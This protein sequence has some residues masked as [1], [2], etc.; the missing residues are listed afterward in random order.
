PPA[1][2]PPMQEREL[3]RRSDPAPEASAP[4]VAVKLDPF[5]AGMVEELE[6]T[7][8]RPLPGAPERVS[9]A[10]PATKPPVIDAPRPFT[11]EAAAPVIPV[12]E[13]L[14]PES[15]GA[16]QTSP[17]EAPPEV[18]PPNAT[19]ASAGAASPAPIP[20]VTAE[21]SFELEMANIL[22]RPRRN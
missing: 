10:S 22:G 13:I 14:P 8:R 11:A 6:E 4:R 1:P 20:T 21:D 15:S 18:L 5:F 12:P 19:P 2:R 3:P 17:K 9:A 16:G 7:L